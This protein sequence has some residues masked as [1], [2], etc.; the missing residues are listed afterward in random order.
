MIGN[1]LAASSRMFGA[2]AAIR[3]LIRWS[4]SAVSAGKTVSIITAV[5]SSSLE[6]LKML[7]VIGALM[8]GTGI[9]ILLVIALME[10]ADRWM[11]W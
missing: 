7:D 1:R 4:M 9:G 5:A 8:F 3:N 6:T 11:K 2:L 10:A